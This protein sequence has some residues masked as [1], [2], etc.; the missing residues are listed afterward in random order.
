MDTEIFLIAIG[1]LAIPLLVLI[2]SKL[3]SR[4]REMSGRVTVLSHRM[5]LAKVASRWSSNWNYLVTFRLC[6]GSELELYTM[7]AEYHALEDGQSGLLT[8]EKDLF[9]HF[10]PDIPQ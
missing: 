1:I 6:D 5:E 10:D 3:F 7:E 9:Y 8:W 2:F 4:N